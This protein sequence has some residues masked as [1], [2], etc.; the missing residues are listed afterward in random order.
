MEILFL[1]KNLVPADPCQIIEGAVKNP[2]S[3]CLK[4]CPEQKLPIDDLCGLFCIC[5][6]GTYL[7]LQKLA[8]VDLSKCS[9]LESNLPSIVPVKQTNSE[10]HHKN[11]K[12]RKERN[13]NHEKKNH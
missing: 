13:N 3:E 11:Q 8:C 9:P 10:R 12:H 1:K 6:N 7:D 4:F 5:S 2:G